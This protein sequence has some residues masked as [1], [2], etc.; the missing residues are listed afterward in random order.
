MDY[1][2]H[3]FLLRKLRGGN[4]LCELIKHSNGL[5]KSEGNVGIWETQTGSKS[6]T[7]GPARLITHHSLVLF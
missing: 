2:K 5:C 1:D 3:C 4:S 7:A 6:E